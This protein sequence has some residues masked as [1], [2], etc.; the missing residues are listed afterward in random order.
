MRQ[1]DTL[2]KS[3]I[4]EPFG[5]N[6]APAIAIAALKALENDQDSIL[7]VLSSD[8]EIKDPSNFRKAVEIGLNDAENEKLVTFG[9]KPE[10][11]ETGYGY[12]ETT[13]SFSLQKLKS[14]EIRN[15]IEKPN[16][17]KA[18]EYFKK[19][20]FLWNS[21]IFLFKSNS[22]IN[23]LK[24]Y[25]PELL[26]SCKQALTKSSKDFDFQRLDKD[27]FGKCA[28]ISI[29]NAIMEK[30]RNACVIPLNAGWSDVGNWGALWE[31]EKKDQ[32]GNVITG[33]IFL[34]NVKDSY[35]YSKKN[36]LV[37]IDLQDLIIVQTDDATLVANKNRSQRIKEIVNK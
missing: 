28:N 30:T 6:T 36:L 25:E 18:N 23:A 10:Y 22:I 34:D 5:K 13:D 2:P 19:N 14:L 31:I 12:I 37:G 29:D 1:I 26:S 8:H 27:S 15:F 9:I 35:V 24:L 32:S 20:H 21:G 3:I 16:Y 4:L 7:L 33:D 11:P 17:E